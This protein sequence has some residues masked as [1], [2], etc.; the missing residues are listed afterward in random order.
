MGIR[1]TC[2]EWVTAEYLTLAL[3]Q[4]SCQPERET[5]C[6]ARCQEGTERIQWMAYNIEWCSDPNNAHHCAPR[7]PA[8]AYDKLFLH[9]WTLPP[10]L[11]QECDF[12][13]ISDFARMKPFTVGVL[14]RGNELESL[15]LSV[16]SWE[17]RGF[18]QYASEFIFM[19][20]EASTEVLQFVADYT[21]PPFNAKVLISHENAGILNGINWLL[22]NST[23][24]YLL[25]LEKDFRLVESLPCAL[26]Q[27]EAGL[28]LLES[29]K[30]E[31]VKYRSRYNAGRPN[32]AEILY[33]DHEDD[34]FDSQPNLLC[35]FYHWIEEPDQR[36][37]DLFEVCHEDPVMY[38]VDAEFCNWTNNPFLISKYWWFEN[39]V[40]RF[41]EFQ[42]S[43]ADFNLET[44]MNW[45]PDAWNN[46]G[47]TIAEGDGMFK[48]ADVRNF[49]A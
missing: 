17:Q 42:G 47:W 13:A 19:I 16:Q 1:D 21:E 27:I 9:E 2:P 30:A 7:P 29:D 49:G 41:K 20:N 22:G 36:W 26:E 31:V 3:D 8:I 44:F 33:R 10:N 28:E 4:W 48:H 34:V 37:P 35:N 38:C 46:R 40:Y 11:P 14:A 15:A 45:A 23:N 39:Y 24:E 5:Y 43:T 12:R 25:F 18:L 32:W 6:T